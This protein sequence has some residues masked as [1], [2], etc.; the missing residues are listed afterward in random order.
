M[1]PPKVDSQEA[2]RYFS[3]LWTVESGNDWFV[4]PLAEDEIVILG[5]G[6]LW[7]NE[8]GTAGG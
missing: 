5:K 1:K 4:D 3:D 7:K 6:R 2:V 8:K